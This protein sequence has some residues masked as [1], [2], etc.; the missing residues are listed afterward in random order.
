MNIRSNFFPSVL[1]RQFVSIFIGLLGTFISSGL[2]F[3]QDSNHSIEPKANPEYLVLITTSKSLNVRKQPTVL[4]PVVASLSSGS[5]VPFIKSGDKENTTVGAAN[6]YQVEYEQGKFGWVSKDYSRKIKASKNKPIPKRVAK[7]E[8]ENQPPV[9]EIKPVAEVKA[10]SPPV[11]EVKPVAEVK[12]DSPP[13]EEIKPVAEV[14]A[15]SPP[16]ETQGFFKGLF[17]SK[18]KNPDKKTS[19]NV[20]V[21][22]EKTWANIDGFRSAKFGMQMH[23]VRKAIYQDF[24]IQGEKITA[25]KHPHE[26]TQNLAVTVKDLL[27][28]SGNSRILYVFGFQS[29]RLIL[30]NMLIGHPA[31]SSLSPQQ[32]VS[33]GNF[34]G[35]YLLKK[36]YQDDGLVSHAK[37]NDGSVL[38]CRGKD[39]KGRMVLLRLSAPQSTN[40]DNE[41]LKIGLNLYYIEK[42]G[43]PDIYQLK[44]EDF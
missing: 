38:I 40:K 34:L 36:R 44:E 23:E 43:Q 30:V 17:S 18:T 1:T 11:E 9:E 5:K 16:V 2:V 10:D 3:A 32:V 14:K 22:Q 21:G 28:D 37:L 8:N 19:Q 7:L 20:K 15:D 27:P 39:Q 25:T 13:V 35:N 29:K 6:W 4:S 41:L 12:A 42:P 26:L 31:D 24:G 33:S